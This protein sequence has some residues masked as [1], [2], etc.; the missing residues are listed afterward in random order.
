MSLFF[1]FAQVSYFFY[2]IHRYTDKNDSLSF[3]KE[4]QFEFGNLQSGSGPHINVRVGEILIHQKWSFTDTMR[5][6]YHLAL[7]HKKKI[8]YLVSFWN[9][10]DL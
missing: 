1:S 6:L 4:Y 3:K 10:M 2:N 5:L 9:F 7:E 8:Q